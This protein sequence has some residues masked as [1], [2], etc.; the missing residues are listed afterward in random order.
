MSID[1]DMQIK[2]FGILKMNYWYT[3]HSRDNDSIYK[4]LKENIMIL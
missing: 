4:L 3:K 2:K 1:R